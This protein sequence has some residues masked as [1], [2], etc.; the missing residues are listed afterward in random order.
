MKK[1]VKAAAA[2]P[3]K[4]KLRSEF[5]KLAT[6]IRDMSK[7]E[8][9]QILKNNEYDVAQEWIDKLTELRNEFARSAQNS[10]PY[11]VAKVIV[12]GNFVGYA[13]SCSKKSGS[14]GWGGRAVIDVTSD[15]DQAMQFASKSEADQALSKGGEYS[16][17]LDNGVGYRF[18]YPYSYDPKMIGTLDE[19][20]SIVNHTD[21]YY[22]GSIEIELEE[23]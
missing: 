13:R 6:E 2:K 21:I 17:Y 10:L 15:I 16:I 22:A 23:V 4:T 5:I 3:N 20:A 8:F 12:D 7:Y 9:V 11:Y 19:T 1:Y 14:R 18:E